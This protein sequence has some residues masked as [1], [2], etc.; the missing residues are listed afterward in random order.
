MIELPRAALRAG[1]IAE[2]AEFFSFGTNDLTQTALGVSRDDAGRFLTAYVEKGIFARDPFVSL[3]VEGVGELIAIAAE[4]GRAARAGP[5]AR[6]LRRAWRRSGLHR[7]LRGDRPRLCQRLALPRADRPARGGAG[8]AAEGQSERAASRSA[9][10]SGFGRCR[11]EGREG[12][13]GFIA[14]GA[15]RLSASPSRLRAVAGSSVAPASA[16]SLAAALAQRVHLVV[17]RGGAA[18][19]RPRPPRAARPP[20][21]SAASIS[22]WRGRP[23]RGSAPSTKASS[24]ISHWSGVKAVIARISLDRSRGSTGARRAIVPLERCRS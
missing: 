3:D 14:A 15:R 19:S 9:I 11:G 2:E 4:R 5:Q 24:R 8:G 17:R 23:C 12:V 18:R 6:H 7:L 21:D 20:R 13:G 22:G 16:S 1:E 10:Q